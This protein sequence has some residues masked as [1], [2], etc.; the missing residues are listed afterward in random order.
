MNVCNHVISRLVRAACVLVCFEYFFLLFFFVGAFR[1]NNFVFFR[2]QHSCFV[3]FLHT[4]FH[5]NLLVWLVSCQ[6]KVLI[7]KI[8]NICHFSFKTKF[9][10]W[11]WF[12]F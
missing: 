12:T 3:I 11:T 4:H 7:L 2:H 8:I 6:L 1:V 5:C 9:W 10:K